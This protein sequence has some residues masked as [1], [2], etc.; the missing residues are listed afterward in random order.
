[1]HRRP[2]WPTLSPLINRNQTV[3][4]AFADVI[5]PVGLRVKANAFDV[6]LYITE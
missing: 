5:A 1:M 3:F 4:P 2:S 6:R